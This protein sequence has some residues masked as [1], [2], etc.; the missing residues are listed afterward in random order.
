LLQYCHGD[1]MIMMVII[2]C[3]INVFLLIES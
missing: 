1:D 2:W 3:Y